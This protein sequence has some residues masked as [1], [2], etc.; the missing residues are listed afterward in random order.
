MNENTLS[1]TGFLMGD[2]I[3]LTGD[4]LFLDGHMICDS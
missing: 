4:I 2:G 3:L 1:A